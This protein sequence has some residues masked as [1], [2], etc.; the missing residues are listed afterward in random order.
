MLFSS[1]IDLPDLLDVVQATLQWLAVPFL[2]WFPAIVVIWLADWVRTVAEVRRGGAR[3]WGWLKTQRLSRL[4]LY[5]FL[6]AVVVAT[7]YSGFRLG[8]AMVKPDASG[9]T[10]A[11]GRYFRWR[12]VW[13]SVTTFSASD[14]LATQALFAAVG[15][16]IAYNVAYVIG[17]GWVANFIAT[18]VA[19]GI[20]L[21]R[22][23]AA[24]V[25]LAG[26]CVWGLATLAHD[27]NYNSEM[28]YLYVMWIVL[29]AGFSL[30]ASRI[31]AMAGVISRR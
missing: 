9:V 25:A 10:I 2:L 20:W 28:V 8:I 15:I 16:L 5:A 31:D 18:V 29:F 22:C 11:D 24:V 1:M 27:P 26:F 23:A 19:L 12:E 7:V 21:G 17:A 6:H 30:S 3:L 13:V 4:A 14:S